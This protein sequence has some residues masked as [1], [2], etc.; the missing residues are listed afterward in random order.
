MRRSWGEPVDADTRRR[1][2]HACEEPGERGDPEASKIF[3]GLKSPLP[4]VQGTSVVMGTVGLVGSVA[5]FTG[6]VSVIPPS[7]DLGRIRILRIG[8]GQENRL[9]LHMKM[10]GGR[11]GK[12]RTQA[13]DLAKED[14]CVM[15]GRCGERVKSDALR[16]MKDGLRGALDRLD[17]G[18]EDRGLSGDG[19]GTSELE[20]E[21]RAGAVDLVVIRCGEARSKGTL[22]D[23]IRDLIAIGVFGAPR[24][25]GGKRSTETKDAAEGVATGRGQGG[26]HRG[27]SPGWKRGIGPEGEGGG[28][29][30]VG[31]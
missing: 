16:E 22:I 7:P 10:Q 2:T 26:S 19:V 18:A 17:F 9:E 13:A 14:A 21:S 27:G 1:P 29:R 11:R 3:L 25:V 12:E 20:G 24:L 30:T 4:R 28:G 23:E 31:R 6:L 5:F 15:V 8:V